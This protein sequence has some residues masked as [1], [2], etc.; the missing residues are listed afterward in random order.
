[1]SN[2]TKIYLATDEQLNT[3]EPQFEAMYKHYYSANGLTRLSDG[4]FARWCKNYHRARGLSRVIYI[5]EINGLIAGFVEGQILINPHAVNPEK[6]GHIAHLFVLPDF[7]RQGTASELHS[8]VQEWF[9]KKSVQSETL[10]VV[11][12]NSIADAFWTAR[13]FQ[14]IFV[15]Y[16]RNFA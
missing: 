3:L 2:N 16:Y 7:R 11:F 9:V 4:G 5:A 12:Q 8:T 13:G 1:M 14:P 6:K 15:K 10:E